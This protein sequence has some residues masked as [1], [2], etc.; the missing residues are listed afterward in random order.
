MLTRDL[1]R[2]HST[3]SSRPHHLHIAATRPLPTSPDR[4]RAMNPRLPMLVSVRLID[5]LLYEQAQLT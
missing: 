2:D 1:T 5:F 4:G 3:P